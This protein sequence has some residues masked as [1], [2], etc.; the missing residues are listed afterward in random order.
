MRD[1]RRDR[2]HSRHACGERVHEP[3]RSDGVGRSFAGGNADCADQAARSA[4]RSR[5]EADSSRALLVRP[6]CETV[7]STP[8]WRSR[9]THSLTLSRT[10]PGDVA[11]APPSAAARADT[12]HRSSSS[13]IASR[14]TDAAR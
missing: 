13:A 1:S 3:A 5:S 12:P 10:L 6:P 7:A 11:G 8:K 2:C 4:A 14:V 9:P